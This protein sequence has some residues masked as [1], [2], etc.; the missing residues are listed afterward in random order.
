MRIK[1][2][3]IVTCLNQIRLLSPS[4]WGFAK[5]YVYQMSAKD[6]IQNI[7]CNLHFNILFYITGCFANRLGVFLYQSMFLRAVKALREKPD[8]CQ[9]RISHPIKKIQSVECTYDIIEKT[10]MG[11]IKKIK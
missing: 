3:A 4:L 11:R 8:N 1:C 2:I 10:K 9:N 5:N 6:G 7:F